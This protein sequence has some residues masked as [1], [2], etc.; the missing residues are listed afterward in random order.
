MAQQKSKRSSRKRRGSGA[1]PRAVPSARREVRAELQAETIRERQKTA[2]AVR[3]PGAHGERPPSLFGGLP[4]SEIAIFAGLIGVI[5]GIAAGNSSALI[6]GGIVC[7]FGVLEF[8]IREHWSGYRSHCTLLAAFPAVGVI[9][10]VAQFWNPVHNRQAIVLPAIPVFALC[11]WLLRKQ[12]RVA[13]QR[14]VA[15]TP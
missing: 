12:F 15:R 8:T 13:R 1:G 9:A 3:T 7:G 6:V 11:F 2:R 10:L 14:R 5:V 4:V